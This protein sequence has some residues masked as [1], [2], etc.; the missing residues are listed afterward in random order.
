VKILNTIIQQN[1]LVT[2]PDILFFWVARM[3]TQD[4]NT[5]KTI[6]KCIFDWFGTG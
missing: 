2:G 3:M 6:Y 4:M 1:D 5:R